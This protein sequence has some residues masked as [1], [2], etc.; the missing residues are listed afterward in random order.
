VPAGSN[1]GRFKLGPAMSWDGIRVED[2][3]RHDSRFPHFALRPHA[4]AGGR[5]D[6]QT[7][8][9]RRYWAAGTMLRE[10]PFGA[11]Q[12]GVRDLGRRIEAEFQGTAFHETYPA[13]SKLRS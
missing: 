2:R 11:F 3:D 10:T 7:G 12:H 1:H 6:G 5:G 13:N 9:W 4:H 8:G